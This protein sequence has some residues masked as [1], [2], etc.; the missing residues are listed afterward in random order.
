MMVSTMQD[1]R[2]EMVCLEFDCDFTQIAA[3]TSGVRGVVGKDESFESG[4]PSAD[5]ERLTE[6]AVNLG[7][8]VDEQTGRAQR[9]ARQQLALVRAELARRQQGGLRERRTPSKTGRQSG[10][11]VPAQFDTVTA[12]EKRVRGIREYHRKK[13]GETVINADPTGPSVTAWLCRLARTLEQEAI[14]Y[15]EGARNYARTPELFPLHIDHSA[16]AFELK[17]VVELL[18][19]CPDLADPPC[20]S[21]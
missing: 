15:E 21:Q 20:E 10:K 17:R 1:G 4:L 14:R 2:S 6:M 9:T 19:D 3:D 8:S 12:K 18:I 5:I 7:K 13:R 16:R 11:S